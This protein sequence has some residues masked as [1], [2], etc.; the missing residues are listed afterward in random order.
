MP[1]HHGIARGLG[2]TPEATLFRQA[3]KGNHPALNQLMTRHEGCV[4][5]FIRRY[6]SGRLAYTETLQTGHIGR[7]WCGV[8]SFHKHS[9]RNLHATF[10][11]N[12]LR[13]RLHYGILP[14]ENRKC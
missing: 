10:T 8:P 3:Q 13:R 4:H 12:S 11:Q 6:G 5:A 1:I 2:S 14:V 9:S 7:E